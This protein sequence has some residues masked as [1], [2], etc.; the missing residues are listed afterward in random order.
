LSDEEPILYL[1][2]ESAK[3][4]KIPDTDKLLPKEIARF[5][6]SA[7]VMDKEEK[8]HL[9]FIQGCGHGGS[10]PHMVHEFIMAIVQNRDSAI[11]AEKAANWTCAGLLGHKSATG[12]G[13]KIYLPDFWNL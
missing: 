10:H 11:D 13:E 1:G 2:K 4:V 12:G 6:K 7:E 5:T 3:K 8:Q 9:S